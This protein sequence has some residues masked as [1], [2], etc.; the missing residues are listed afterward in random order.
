M[1]TVNACLIAGAVY[2]YNVGGNG[3]ATFVG[4]A[5]APAANTYDYSG[6]GITWGDDFVGY[7]PATH[8]IDVTWCL[9]LGLIKR[10]NSC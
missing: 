6:R 8:G 9:F 1:A 2:T 10:L 7:V 4:K 5:V 3:A